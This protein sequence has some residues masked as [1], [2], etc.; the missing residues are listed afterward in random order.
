MGTDKA[1]LRLDRTAG[2]AGSEPGEGTTLAEHA[3][4][5]LA[6]VCPEVVIA[7]RGRA[8]LPGWRSIEDGPGRGPAA[9]LL[10][11]AGAAPGRPVL[12]LAC[13]LPAVPVALLA[14]LAERG[15]RG[16]ADCTAVRTARGLEPLVCHYSP[17]ALSALAEQVAA[18]RYALHS[19]FDRG[20]LLVELV[21]GEDLERF[22]DPA[23]MLANLNL[24]EDLE[25]FGSEREPRPR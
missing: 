23:R 20:D 8:V 2:R 1:L 21:E 19:L 22:G 24:P 5:R 13:D 18:G 25:A 10:G 17:R 12:A 16:G 11:A 14:E 3:A 15:A 4:R 7:D 9:G 6:A